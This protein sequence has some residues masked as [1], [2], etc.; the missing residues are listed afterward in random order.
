[1]GYAYL[2]IPARPRDHG[3]ARLPDLLFDEPTSMFIQRIAQ[4]YPSIYLHTTILSI[5]FLSSF[6]VQVDSTIK[7]EWCS[8]A[9]V[10]YHGVVC[11][12][13]LRKSFCKLS[14]CL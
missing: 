9:C 8:V 7:I 2:A 14:R 1:M 12:Y 5:N 4:R 6:V 3:V 10:F 11:Y 13:L